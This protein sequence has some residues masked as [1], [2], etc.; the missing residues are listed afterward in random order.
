[1]NPYL[2]FVNKIKQDQEAARTIAPDARVRNAADSGDVV[3]LFSPHPDDECITGLLPF[4]LMTQ[5]G[6][7]VVNVP[8]TFGSETDRRAGRM[9]ELKNACDYLG[10]SIH[11]VRPDFQPLEVSDVVRVL[12]Q[13]QPEIL[14]MPHSGDWN[15]R[16]VEVHFLVLEA[17]KCMGDSFSCTVVETEFWGAMDDPN[18]MVEGRPEMVAELVAATALHEG[19]VAR[20]PYHL[21]LPAW[22]QDNVRRGSELVGGQGTGAPAFTFATLYRVRKWNHGKF[23]QTLE[24]IQ[25][26]AADRPELEQWKWKLL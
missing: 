9:N 16:H 15:T 23:F 17:L 4:R 26:P 24:N 10:W 8:V 25:V 22:M 7:R 6:C 11:R 19:E 5:L 21:M 20:N 18:L 13:V 2:S 14:F 1:M 12:D 3:L